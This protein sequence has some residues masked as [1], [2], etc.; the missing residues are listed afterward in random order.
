MP[1]RPVGAA[2]VAKRVR[3]FSRG[4]Q[5]LEFLNVRNPASVADVARAAR[6]ARTTAFRMLETLA[7]D[8]YV[9]RVE[10]DGRYRLTSKVRNL[11]G[12]FE[13]ESWIAEVARPE[14]KALSAQSRWPVAIATLSGGAMLV[15]ETT[16]HD[17]PLVFDR[18]STGFRVPVLGSASGRAVLAF[19]PEM[20]RE[21]LLTLVLDSEGGGLDRSYWRRLLEDV[22]KA[23]YAVYSRPG[24]R[25]GSLAAPIFGQDG[26]V[27]AAL[28]TRYFEAVLTRP[29]ALD[30]LLPS[31]KATAQAIGA[32]LSGDLAGSDP[33][34]PALA[35]QR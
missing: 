19:L 26:V 10:P 29:Q 7:D 6:M 13:D 16:D 4:L 5:V 12:G 32:R 35:A 11:A 34:A 17:T 27:R 33:S 23:G 8:G 1:R 14:M 31:L 22:R 15:R 3:A 2:S 24:A 9:D 20:A 21:S 18:T 30:S 28:S 25:E